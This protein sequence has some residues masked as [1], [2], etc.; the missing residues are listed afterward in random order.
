[1]PDPEVYIMNGGSS[2]SGMLR[3]KIG[4]KACFFWE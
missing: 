4:S 3:Y 1:M 2:I